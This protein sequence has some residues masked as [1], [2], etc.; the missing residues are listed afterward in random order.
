MA[1]GEQDMYVCM[2]VYMYVLYA[3]LYI[4]IQLCACKDTYTNNSGKDK[5]H[6]R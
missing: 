1:G 6:V 3:N 2:Y 4:W 5:H